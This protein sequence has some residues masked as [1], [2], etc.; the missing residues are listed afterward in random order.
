LA[1]M[2]IGEIWGGVNGYLM[3]TRVRRK[4]VGK[5]K[6]D[7]CHRRMLSVGRVVQ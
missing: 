1:K 4:E 7:D 3:S 6:I 5:G 2:P